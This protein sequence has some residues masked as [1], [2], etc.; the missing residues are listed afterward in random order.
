MKTQRQLIS[1]AYSSERSRTR[2]M[3]AR[4]AMAGLVLVFTSAASA[5]LMPD[6][7]VRHVGVDGF[8]FGFQVPVAVV[9]DSEGAVYINGS[10]NRSR[11]TDMLT[12]KYA[13]DGTEVWSV[14]YD[15]PSGSPDSGK[16]IAIDSAGDILVLGQS[17]CD[18]LVIKYDASDGSVIWT[19]QHDGG[20]C[21]ESGNALTTDDAGNIYVTGSTRPSGFDHQE[22]FYTYKLD[23]A[24][25]ILWTATYDG[26]GQPMF[27]NDIPVDIALDS[28]G[29]VFVTG[30][31]NDAGGHPDFL[32]IKYR[33]TD[34]T[35]LWLARLVAPGSGESVA[36][37]ISPEDD[38]YVT[39]ASPR[40]FTPLTTVK[41]DGNDGSEI[42][43][44][45]NNL[46]TFG[47]A[48]G[49][50]LD[51]AGDVYVTGSL[52]PDGDRSNQND[53]VVTMR[54]RAADGA[55]Q[56]LSIYGENQIGK[57]DG[58]NAIAIDAQDNVFVTGHTSSFGA[59]N[60]L[61]LLQY[62][63]A[64]GQLVDQGTFDVPTESGKGQILALDSAQN[65]IVAG[66]TRADPSGFMDFLTLKYPGLG[67]APPIV[68]GSFTIVRGQL[69]S[70][71]LPDLFDS[72]DSRL[73]VRTATFAPQPGP[74]VQVEVQ[75]TS[76]EPSPSELRFRLESAV[77]QS[78]VQQRILMYD[79]V[80]QSYE[81]V[82]L[83]TAATSDTVVEV[84]IS[85]NPSRFIEPGTGAMKTLMTWEPL[86]FAGWIMT[87][88][89]DQTV[90]S[91]T[92]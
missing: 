35:Q 46:G 25:N 33:G 67:S 76:S 66:T 53:N 56:W 34:G 39:G 64:S 20:N 5:Q 40:G 70:G 81:E 6:W 7:D 78:S 27:G 3:A 91:L 28:H 60:D 85:D 4:L 30:P 54:L 31:S 2:P 43:V 57:L 69:I 58:G 84:V 59:S 55:R 88:E 32:T 38:V 19:N 9:S 75:G 29:D 15:G 21:P 11:F 44:S 52:D 65:V 41:H 86:A 48:F 18:F 89:I 71:N 62:A 79:F 1:N 17:E 36:L 47:H 72:D 22:D 92:P 14:I 68:P 23:S 50:A 73:V 42:W 26:P 16:G 8:F 10:I 77:D 90:W 82:D 49:M 51:S 83:R 87:A 61:I 74:P 63:A 80:A 13:P 24:G 12:V 45:V 37:L